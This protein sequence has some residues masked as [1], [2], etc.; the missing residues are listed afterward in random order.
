MRSVHSVYGV[1]KKGALQLLKNALIYT[2][3]T[4]NVLKS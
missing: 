1:L 2:E 3:D 4:H